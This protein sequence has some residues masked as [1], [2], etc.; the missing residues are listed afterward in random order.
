M[1]DQNNNYLVNLSILINCLLGNVL[2]LLG[3]V[4]SQSLLGVKELRCENGK[5][6]RMRRMAV[7]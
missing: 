5:T 3:E 2:T 1:L 7:M 6:E 4:T